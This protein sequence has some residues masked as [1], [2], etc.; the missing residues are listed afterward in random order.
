M[1]AEPTPACCGEY[2]CTRSQPIRVARSELTGMWYAVTEHAERA[3]GGF[4]ARQK[5]MLHPADAAQLET[6][7]QAMLAQLA[8]LGIKEMAEPDLVRE[9]AADPER[10]KVARTEAPEVE[11]RWCG[12]PLHETLSGTF[13]G[14]D[15]KLICSQFGSGNPIATHEPRAVAGG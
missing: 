7:H 11:C 1:A 2:R 4:E 3:N 14:P 12:E 6:A 13:R 8:P 5:H 15:G 10:G 9:Y